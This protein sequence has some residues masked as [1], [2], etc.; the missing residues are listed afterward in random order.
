MIR[1]SQIK[2]DIHHTETDLIHKICKILGVREDS[3]LSYTRKKQSLDAR[4]KPQLY[5]VY[6]VDVKV[7][8]ENIIKKR[9]KKNKDSNI[10]FQPK[11]KK[12]SIKVCGSRPLPHRPVV[13]GTGPAGLFCGYELA[14]LGYRPVLLE[15]GAPLEERI[16]DVEDFWTTGVLNPESNVQFGEGGA[17]TFSD[18]KLNTQIGRAHV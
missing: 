6:T 10:V 14:R 16:K 9:M 12:Y 13:I 15:R 18:G 5:Y 11:E 2:L 8:N 3:L 7:K 17:G 4:K 1:I